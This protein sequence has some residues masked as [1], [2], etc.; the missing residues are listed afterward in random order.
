MP[1][2]GGVPYMPPPMLKAGRMNS[3]LR[4]STTTRLVVRLDSFWPTRDLGAG[5]RRPAL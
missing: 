5:A 4:T 3:M 2:S 1:R